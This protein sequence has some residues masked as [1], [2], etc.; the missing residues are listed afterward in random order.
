ML[1]ASSVSLLPNIPDPIPK[2]PRRHDLLLGV[3]LHA[4][5]SLNVQ[6]AVEGIVPAGERKH[7]HRGGDTDVDPDH[8][9]FD[10][11]F[12][13][14]RGFAGV[15]ENRSAVAVSG[16]VSGLDGVFG[17]TIFNKQPADSRGSATI[18]ERV[19]SLARQIEQFGSGS[20]IR[21]L[22]CGR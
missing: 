7:R 9:G 14:A 11:V 15:S 8:A 17:K 1:G 10:A 12:E 21:Q 19:N 13:F 3:K 6:I 22:H 5:F 20:G 18:K 4:F 16:F 2:P